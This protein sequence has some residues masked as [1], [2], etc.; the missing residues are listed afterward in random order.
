MFAPWT[1]SAQ[2]S[3]PNAPVVVITRSRFHWTQLSSPKAE[4]TAAT[5]IWSGSP[6]ALSASFFGTLIAIV[7]ANVTT[8]RTNAAAIGAN[9]ESP[10]NRTALTAVSTGV[11]MKQAMNQGLMI[12]RSIAWKAPT[13]VRSSVFASP[14]MIVCA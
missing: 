6:A 11:P 7:T 12:A 13:K 14:G 2:Q 3:R 10:M 9:P 8:Y 1:S 5:S 4:R